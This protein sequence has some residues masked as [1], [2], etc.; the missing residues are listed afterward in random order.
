EKVSAAVPLPDQNA[1]LVEYKQGKTKGLVLFSLADGEQLWKNDF[2]GMKGGSEIQPSPQVD[3]RGDIYYPYGKNLLK[4][5]GGSG[6][7]QWTLEASKAIKDLFFDTDETQL[8]M[9]SGSVTNAFRQDNTEGEASVVQGNVGKFEIAAIDLSTGQTNWSHDYK[10]KYA[11][12]RLGASDLVLFHST[13]FNFIDLQTGNKKWKSEPKYVGGDRNEGLIVDDR[14]ILAANLSAIS[15]KTNFYFLDDTGKK[16]WKKTPY[17]VGAIS[18]L[19]W[20]E[21]GLLFVSEKGANIQN[22]ETGKDTWERD[23]YISSQGYPILVNADDEG[24]PLL[25]TWGNLIR[26]LPEQ[27]DWEPFAGGLDLF[28]EM[29]TSFER[30]PTGYRITSAQNALMIDQEGNKIYHTYHPA[31]EQSFGSRLLLSMASVALSTANLATGVNSITYAAAGELADNDDYREKSVGY[32]QLY[33]LGEGIS[34]SILAEANR[35]FKE[36]VATPNYKLIL[37]TKDKQIGLVKVDL[38]TGEDAGFVVTDDRTPE[39]VLDSVDDKLFFKTSSKNVAM[40]LMK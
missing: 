31:P 33:G 20:V 40:Y 3:Q 22:M 38:E 2:E 10:A 14:G 21:S 7:I 9:A 35:R 8:I 12:C 28:G 24:N 25:L 15:G 26:V 6:E 39:F 1:L 37:T 30:L 27:E 4:I 13:S 29:P 18:Y 16:K 19:D 23:K 32:G 36:D 11:G 17:T 5:N 34:E